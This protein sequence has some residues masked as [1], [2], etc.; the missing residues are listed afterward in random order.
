MSTTDPA[1]ADD[2][3]YY[4]VARN[5]AYVFTRADFQNYGYAVSL[6]SFCD[7]LEAWNPENFT[8][9]DINTTGTEWL[10]TSADRNFTSSGIA[11]SLGPEQAFYAFLS[12]TTYQILSDLQLNKSNHPTSDYQSWAW[13]YCSEFGYFQVSNAS[14]PTSM[15]SR[16]FNVSTYALEECKSVFPYAPD[17][18]NVDSILKYGG[19]NMTPSNTMFTDGEY[20]PWRT[21]SVL[22]DKKINPSAIVRES[23][24]EIPA[25]NVPPEGSKVFGQVY[26]GE[27]HVPDLSEYIEEVGSAAVTPADIGFELF[28]EALEEWLEC[29]GE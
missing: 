23:T 27:V 22:A 6:G 24:T 1:V 2:S 7:Y 8:G 4:S 21:L 3:T 10:R 13:Q 16:F 12:A 25:C 11:A 18:P 5:L 29:F 26:P 19:W 14:D 28:S 20:D 15:I 17:L 9:F